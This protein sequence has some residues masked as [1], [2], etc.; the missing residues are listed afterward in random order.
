MRELSLPSLFDNPPAVV[1]PAVAETPAREVRRC[2]QIAKDFIRWCFSFGPNYRNS[3]DVI[4]LR[5]FCQ[6]TKMKVR[7]TEEREVLVEARRLY[8]KRIEQ[9]TKKTEAPGLLL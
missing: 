1:P 4:N 7:D 2:E 5:T 8:L 9:M 3:P 6:T